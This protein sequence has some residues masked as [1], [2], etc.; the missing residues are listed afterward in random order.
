MCAF[1]KIISSSECYLTS[2]AKF[3]PK[4]LV[5][6]NTVVAEVL[7]LIDTVFVQSQS[8][9]VALPPAACT[10]CHP[11]LRTSPRVGHSLSFPAEPWTCP[12]CKH[13]DSSEYS[14]RMFLE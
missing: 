5:C 13:L 2:F 10:C 7:F 6:V 9:A 11:A 3:L 12:E 4:V 1:Q 14:R 8:W